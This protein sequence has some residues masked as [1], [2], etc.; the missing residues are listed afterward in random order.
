MV[1]SDDTGLVLPAFAML[2]Q[3]DFLRLVSPASGVEEVAVLQQAIGLTTFDAEHG[4]PGAPRGMNS[5]SIAM[6]R[7]MAVPLTCVVLIPK[8]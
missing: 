7:L 6:M 2:Q 4:L 3:Q 8:M 5:A 1:A